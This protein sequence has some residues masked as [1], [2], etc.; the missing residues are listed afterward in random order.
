MLKYLTALSICLLVLSASLQAQKNLPAFSFNDLD[1]R[2][3]TKADLREDLPTIVFFFDPYCDHC[4]QQAKWIKEAGDQF[5]DI[6][7]VWVTTESE[8][9]ASQEF[10]LEYFGGGKWEHVYFLIDSNFL[11]DGFFGYSEVP[12]IYIYNAS[13]QRLKSF[14]KETPAEILLRFL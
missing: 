7:M 13:G 14:S 1:G 8:T 12:S 6:Q 4:Q 10:S 2:A 11:F 3:F 9:K 5:K